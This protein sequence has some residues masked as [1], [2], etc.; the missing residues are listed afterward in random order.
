MDRLWRPWRMQYVSSADDDGNCIFCEHLAKEGEEATHV[1]YRARDVFV[2]LNAFPYNSGHVMIAPTRH[3]GE[4]HDLTV[5]ERGRLMEVT[6]LAVD[7]IREALSAHGF[8]VGMNLGRVAG[9]G[10]PGHLHIHV[11]PRWGG[12]T[13]FMPVVGDTKVLPEML[14]DTATRLRPFFSSLPTPGVGREEKND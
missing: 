3:I 2:V 8:N 7:A 4:L 12:D 5:S 1:L 11:V 10:I 6:A 14:D 13:N 9:A